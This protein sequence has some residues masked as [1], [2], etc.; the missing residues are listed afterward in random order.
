MPTTRDSLYA[1]TIGIDRLELLMH[2]ISI[3]KIFIVYSPP[4]PLRGTRL[5][6]VPF[7][8]VYTQSTFD[9]KR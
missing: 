4:V 3:I 2:M 7:K 8:S 6:I 1:T 9:D 5:A